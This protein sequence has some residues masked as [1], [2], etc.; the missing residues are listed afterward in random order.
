MRTKETVEGQLSWSR[1]YSWAT[2]TRGSARTSRRGTTAWLVFDSGGDL[3]QYRCYWINGPSG[4]HVVETGSALSDVDAV[5]WAAARTS[6]AR[7]ECPITA[8]TGPASPQPQAGSPGSGDPADPK[9]LVDP[10]SQSSPNLD[11]PLRRHHP[12]IDAGQEWR[13]ERSPSPDLPSSPRV[14]KESDRDR[15]RVHA[16]MR[17]ALC[18]L[19]RTF[20]HHPSRPHRVSRR[21]G[22]CGSQGA[23]AAGRSPLVA[24]AKSSL[25]FRRP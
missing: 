24:R 23:R 4:D 18:R 2:A 3:Y 15:W 19:D 8:R 16:E 13:H 1:F 6:N 5:A 25:P 10:T 14:T 17:R 9:T 22:E 7:S 20:G 12:Q 21:G 11:Q